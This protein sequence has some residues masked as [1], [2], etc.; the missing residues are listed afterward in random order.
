MRRSI[1]MIVPAV[2]I[3]ALTGCHSS[4]WYNGR[5]ATSANC[6][7][8][9]GFGKVCVLGQC[10]EC[11]LDGDCKTGFRCRESVCV[12]RPECESPSDCGN[13]RRCELGKCVWAAPEPQC[14]PGSWRPRVCSRR[15]LRRGNLSGRAASAGPLPRTRQR[16][17]LSWFSGAHRQVARNAGGGRRVPGLASDEGGPRGSYRRREDSGLQ[18]DARPATR[19]GGEEIPRRPGYPPRPPLHRQLRGHASHVHEPD[20][21]VPPA[22][23][24]GRPEGPRVGAAAR[25]RRR[26][27]FGGGL[28]D[29]EA[30]D[31][32]AAH[33]PR[34]EVARS[35]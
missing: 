3:L 12:P 1:R 8:Q 34:H 10:Q 5:C 29:G 25:A 15:G 19:R 31:A 13:G 11:G 14:G 4:E 32:A 28:R 16:L 26:C 35:R 33:G 30:L 2:A 18:R 6:A 20:R 24:Q 22:E 21:G 9:P 23:S 7:K 17:L 27:P